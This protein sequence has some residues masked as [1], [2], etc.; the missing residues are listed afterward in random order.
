MQTVLMAL[1]P[2]VR[3]LPMLKG[4][5]LNA[6]AIDATRT[7]AMRIQ[8]P[9]ADLANLFIPTVGIVPT[10]PPERYHRDPEQV[11]MQPMHMLHA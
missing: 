8:E 4:A 7:P 11:C 1:E 10:S 9:L 2:T 3:H 5:I 6:S